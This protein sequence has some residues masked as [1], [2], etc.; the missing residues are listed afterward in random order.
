MHLEKG[1][2][3]GI[4]WAVKEP[5]HASKLLKQMFPWS[6]STNSIRSSSLSAK[7]HI[8]E[9]YEC[10]EKS[11]HKLINEIYRQRRASDIMQHGLFRTNHTRTVVPVSYIMACRSRSSLCIDLLSSWTLEK[12]PRG[13]RTCGQLL[14]TRHINWIGSYGSQ[15]NRAN[16]VAN[17]SRV[18]YIDQ[19]WRHSLYFG[20]NLLNI[21]LHAGSCI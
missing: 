6:N 9:R 13:I 17:L 7:H 18:V 1:T 14:S 19:S 16:H 2:T 12:K 5:V 11:S 3:A 20:S 15:D 21:R 4:N 10:M 8:C